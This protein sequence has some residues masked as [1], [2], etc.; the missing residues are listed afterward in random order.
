M[1]GRYRVAA[2]L[3]QVACVTVVLAWLLFVWRL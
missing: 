1:R 2:W 3:G